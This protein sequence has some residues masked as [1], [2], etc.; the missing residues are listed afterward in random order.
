MMNRECFTC[1]KLKN[2]S[3]V[4]VELVLRGHVCHFF[5]MAPEPV[6]EARSDTVKTFGFIPAVRNMMCVPR[7]PQ[8]EERLRMSFATPAPG[9]TYSERR[10]QLDVMSYGDVRHL[11]VD[12]YKK[13]DGS[14]LL[15]QLET[16]AVASM[17]QTR[18]T[19]LD[20][21]LSNGLI[22]PD[23]QQG[24][25][26]MAQQFAPPPMPPGIPAQQPM[27]GAPPPFAPQGAQPPPAPPMAPPMPPQAAPPPPYGMAPPPGSAPP[28]ATAQEAAQAAVAPPPPPVEAAPTGKK[29]SA[30]GAA[31]APAPPPPPPSPMAAPQQQFAAPQWQAPPLPTAA[32]QQPQFAPPGAAPAVVDFSPVLQVLNQVGSAVNTV[33]AAADTNTTKLLA[34]VNELKT[35]LIAQT[36][37]IQHIYLTTPALQQH[38]QGKDLGDVMKFLAYLQ[39]YVPR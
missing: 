34:A 5:E 30:K 2:C 6:I 21:E 35:I 14:Q 16:L 20:F 38:T 15:T 26:P 31:V 13:P 18:Q 19:V 11:A 28:V 29:K 8:Q 12:H 7:N 24:E 9:T 33:G 23:N 10:K 37:G 4:D 39:A 22:V 36:V 27:P 1:I 17:A 3:K 25:A 32:P